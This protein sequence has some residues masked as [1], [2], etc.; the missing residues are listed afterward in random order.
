VWACGIVYYTL[1]YQGIPFR[2]AVPTD[3]N[4]ASY[5][6]KRNN[7]GFEAF[8][9]LPHGCRELMYRILE[10]NAKKRITIEGI[11]Q[12]AWFK[13]IESCSEISPKKLRQ[14]HH[15]ISPEILKEIQNTEEVNGGDYNSKK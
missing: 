2:M 11:K 3:P 9:R 10:P 5:L 8:E 12:D 15:H 14:S 1:V 4:F 13:S 7:K 6:E